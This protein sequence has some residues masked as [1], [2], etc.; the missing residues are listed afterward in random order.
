MMKDQSISRDATPV[1][2]AR[3]AVTQ[4]DLTRPDWMTSVPRDVNLLWLDKNENADPALAAVTQRVIAEID[5]VALST[6]PECAPLYRKLA[7]YLSIGPEN[8]LLAAGSDGVI[9]SVFE[10]FA[11]PGDVVMH[12]QPTFA[13]YSVYSKMYGVSAAP[14]EYLPSDTGPRLDVDAVVDGIKRIRPKIVCLPN[15]DSPTGTVYPPDE[16]RRIVEA[17]GRERALMLIDE[18][19]YPFYDQ[20]A[21][22]WIERYPNLVIARTFAKAWGLAGL[23]IGYAV[24]SP[25]VT[26]LLHKVRPMYEVNTIAVAAMERM[27]DYHDEMMAS[28]RRLNAGRDGFLAAM[29]RLGFRTLPSEGNFLHVAFGQAAERVHAALEGQVLYRKDSPDAC[30][31]GFSRFTATTEERFAPVIRRIGDAMNGRG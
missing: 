31:K 27:L 12:T 10:A 14:L 30:L 13:M 21:I 16:L 8:L 6:Y 4:D 11:N 29:K 23:R 3:K 7:N 2:E 28:V 20:T 25:E 24:S 17:A 9:R 1:P 15:P 19:Y 26:K 5:P 18:A 22:G